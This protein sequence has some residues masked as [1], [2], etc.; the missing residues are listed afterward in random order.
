MAREDG[1]ATEVNESKRMMKAGD[2][3]REAKSWQR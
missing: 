2:G 1:Y 3:H